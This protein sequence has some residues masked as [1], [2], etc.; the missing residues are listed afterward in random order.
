[1]RTFF[2][3]FA[4]SNA[5]LRKATAT[6]VCLLVAAVVPGCA[7]ASESFIP[8]R[9]AR[10]IPMDGVTFAY[11]G[12]EALSQYGYEEIIQRAVDAGFLRY[13]TP[14]QPKAQN[15]VGQTM[16]D[17][18]SQAWPVFTQWAVAAAIT[19]QVDSPAPGPA[20]VVALGMLV[21]GLVSAGAVGAMVL[22]SSSATATATAVPTAT[23]TTTTTSPPA[24]S[25]RDRW[26]CSASCNV[27]QINPKVVCPARVTGSAGGPNEPV[28]CVE[29]KRSATQSTP[30]GCYPRHCQCRC[31]RR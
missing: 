2:D 25:N 27:Q 17:A 10:S 23:A 29:A 19:S 15:L 8:L 6:A 5:L 24:T 1:M 22:T 28:A 31:S 9:P 4:P 11:I 21:V 30:A 14:E 7:S 18:A 13:P 20:D 3:W 26:Q 16:A 12:R